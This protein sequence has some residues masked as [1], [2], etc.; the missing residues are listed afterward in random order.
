MKRTQNVGECAFTP[1]TTHLARLPV[2]IWLDADNARQKC[3]VGRI[4]PRRDIVGEH[5]R[6]LIDRGLWVGQAVDA[7][8]RLAILCPAL[9]GEWGGGLGLKAE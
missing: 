5:R 4:H 7:G 3:G 6:G 2:R 8:Q 9:W 1:G